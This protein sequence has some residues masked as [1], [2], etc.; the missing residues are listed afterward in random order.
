[1]CFS[2]FTAQS[3][4]LTLSFASFPLVKTFSLDLLLL[5]NF[6]PHS[7]GF[8]FQNL[9]SFLLVGRKTRRKQFAAGHNLL[10]R[11]EVLLKAVETLSA[12]ICS[13]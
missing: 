8:Q 3:L 6:D 10:C 11:A 2:E 4:S 13:A 7:L 12:R 9:D 5:G 1:M